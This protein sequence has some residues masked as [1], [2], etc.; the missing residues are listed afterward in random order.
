MAVVDVHISVYAPEGNQAIAQAQIRERV[1][2]V[3]P[4]VD[5][6]REVDW[7]LVKEQVEGLAEEASTKVLSQID[8]YQTYLSARGKLPPEGAPDPGGNGHSER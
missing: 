7:Q 4:V 1:P 8:D 5:A 6:L 2:T 3:P